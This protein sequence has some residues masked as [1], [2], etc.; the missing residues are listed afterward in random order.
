MVT[1]ADGAGVAEEWVAV[2]CGGETPADKD[3]A[4]MSVRTVAKLVPNILVVE[5]PRSSGNVCVLPKMGDGVG[6]P[7]GGA[8]EVQCAVWV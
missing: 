1:V 4:I 2:G 5:V 7:T 6:S 8:S 3:M